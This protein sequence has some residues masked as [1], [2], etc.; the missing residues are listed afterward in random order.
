MGIKKDNDAEHARHNREARLHDRAA[1][2]ARLPLGQ[3]RP[4]LELQPRGLFGDADIDGRAGKDRGRRQSQLAGPRRGTHA[5]AVQ[6]GDQTPAFCRRSIAW[7][8]NSARG[9]SPPI[10]NIR[11]DSWFGS[12]LVTF[13]KRR[14]RPGGKDTT[15]SGPR[16]TYSTSPFSFS[17]LARQV[18]V[19][20]IKVS[21]VSWLCISGPWPGFAL[22][23]PR[24]N[25]SL[26]LIAASCAAWSPTGDV[27]APPEP[28]G[29]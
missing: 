13:S 14:I 22:Q 25:P 15:S 8:V 28:F 20:G 21:L 11:I 10:T 7:S 6:S 5:Q 12:P 2:V 3:Q 23:Y 19:I 29:G 26:I 27:T 24:L 4:S 16:S 9:P 18:P 17:Q 1:F